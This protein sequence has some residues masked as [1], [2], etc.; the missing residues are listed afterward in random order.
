MKNIK[1]IHTFGTSFTAGGGYNW[2]LTEDIMSEHPILRDRFDKLHS[3]YDEEPKTKFH[4]SWP[5][6]LQALLSG[7]VKVF[8]HAKE[9][10]GNETMY[11]ITNDFEIDKTTVFFGHT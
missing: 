1:E 9:G 8:N 2:D 5:G 4:Y 3:F 11:R 6:Q 10:F 7:K